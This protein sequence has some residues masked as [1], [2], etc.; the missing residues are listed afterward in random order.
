MLVTQ[1][2]YQV[3]QSTVFFV[4]M[5]L[6]NE[7]TAVVFR[8]ELLIGKGRKFMFQV[9]LLV[10]MWIVLYVHMQCKYCSGSA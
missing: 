1:F 4:V 5:E 6:G 3:F 7:M 9:V 10:N 8:Q 2:V